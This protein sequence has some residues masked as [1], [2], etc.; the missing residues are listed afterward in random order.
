MTDH[1]DA[2]ITDNY[3]IKIYFTNIQFVL[4]ISL[5]SHPRKTGVESNL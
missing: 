4:M 2:I 3:A 5:T 1:M